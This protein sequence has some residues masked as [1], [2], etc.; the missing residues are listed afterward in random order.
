MNVGILTFQFANNYGALLQA[1]ALQKTI[2]GRLG[3]KV[4]ILNYTGKSN[5][6]SYSINPFIA[7]N[8]RQFIK[9]IVLYPKKYK[10]YKLFD[11]FR[12]NYLKIKNEKVEEIPFRDYDAIIVG[13]DQVW[14]FSITGSD[15][16]YFLNNDNPDQCVRLAYAVSADDYFPEVK[17]IGQFKSMMSKFHAISVREKQL[18]ENIQNKTGILTQLVCDPV[19]LLDRDM[20]RQLA[21]EPQCLPS[22]YIFLYLLKY[23][24]Q[25]ESFASSLSS[26]YGIPILVAHPTTRKLTK[27][28]KLLTNIGP[29]EFISLI[30]NSTFVLTNSFHALAFATIFEKKSY[31]GLIEGSSNRIR[32]L[33]EVNGLSVQEVSGN[34]GIFSVDP[35]HSDKDMM[36]ELISSSIKYIDKDI[37][38]GI[39]ENCNRSV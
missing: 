4:E 3:E 24:A 11:Q 30:L 13:S 39:Y 14:S 22:K 12:Y 9:R 23:D 5:S 26:K 20:W 28:G 17:F 21:N 34:V 8:L 2:E 37:I 25:I 38:G 15:L 18:Q 10:Q 33:I 31:V 32:N 35:M 6:S 36:K 29:R 1:Y 27:V 16:T 7:K 19:F